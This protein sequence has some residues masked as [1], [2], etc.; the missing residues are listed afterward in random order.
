ML[1]RT[2]CFGLLG[3]TLSTLPLFRSENPPANVVSVLQKLESDYNE[4]K[5]KVLA[6]LPLEQ[7]QPLSVDPEKI[8]S[9]TSYI[10]AQV[11]LSLLIQ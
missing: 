6:G 4:L 5:D 9:G 2:S 7:L 11:R 8:I 10:P 1:T 3:L